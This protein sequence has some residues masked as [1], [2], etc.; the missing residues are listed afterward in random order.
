MRGARAAS[1]AAR[2]TALKVAS[3]F[4]TPLLI[5]LGAYAVLRSGGLLYR[6]GL[7]FGFTSG[8]HFSVPHQRLA[9]FVLGLVALTVGVVFSFTLA[10]ILRLLPPI[11]RVIVGLE[12]TVLVVLIVVLVSTKTI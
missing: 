2:S 6:V 5:L 1:H 7:H 11:R 10:R 4:L 12:A 8:F 9:A 3:L